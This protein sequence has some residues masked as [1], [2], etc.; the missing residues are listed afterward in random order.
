MGCSQS[1]TI[2]KTNNINNKENQQEEKRNE[3]KVS[4]KGKT[5]NSNTNYPISVKKFMDSITNRNIQEI[6]DSFTPDLLKDTP[7]NEAFSF[8]NDFITD[9]ETESSEIIFD[10]DSFNSEEN[11][12]IFKSIFN[13]NFSFK[14]KKVKIFFFEECIGGYEYIED[15]IVMK[16]DEEISNTNYLVVYDIAK[17]KICKDHQRLEISNH[18]NFLVVTPKIRAEHQKSLSFKILLNDEEQELLTFNNLNGDS[19]LQS[20]GAIISGEGILEI[21]DEFESIPRKIVLDTSKNREKYKGYIL[22]SKEI[23]SEID[24]KAKTINDKYFLDWV[25]ANNLYKGNESHICFYRRLLN[26][27]MKSM[28]YEFSEKS[29][30]IRDEEG[31]G[32]MLKYGKSD[33]GGHSDLYINVC[34]LNNLKARSL[35]SSQHCYPEVFI[36]NIGWLPVEATSR[37]IEDFGEIDNF[38]KILTIANSFL[39]HDFTNILKN[40][41]ES[42]LFKIDG[43]SPS[44]IFINDENKFDAKWGTVLENG[45]VVF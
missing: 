14:E 20:H 39:Q 21:I 26:V 12:Y 10:Q 35:I 43:Q 40:N 5:Q 4:K 9:R 2:E 25:E 41:R 30:K 13:M 18:S 36:D 38:G 1:N 3:N 31:L 37:C 22:S 44:V 6:I 29:C 45:E 24:S 42:N 34:L 7:T 16:D 23:P 8:F 17:R 15:S 27:L 32:G 19:N 11:S 28:N 33:C